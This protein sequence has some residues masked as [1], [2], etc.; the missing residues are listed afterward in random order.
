MKY[1]SMFVLAAAAL[2]PVL[3]A[4]A[5]PKKVLVVTV[6]LGYRH[7]PSIAEA[8]K[9]LPQLAAADGRFAV[10]FVSQPPGAPT[11][12]ATPKPGPAGAEDP[13]F[14]AAKAKFE[15]DRQAFQEAT[16]KWTP[17]VVA[18]L[19]ALSPQNLKKYDAVLFMSTTGDLPL[20]DKQGFLDW[21]AAGHAFIGVHAA[22]DTFHGYPA[23][24]D[25]IG[26]EFKTHG[27]QVAVECLNE[28]P[29][30]A[31]MAHLPANWPVFD[32][33]YQFKNF[34]RAKVHGLLGLDKHPNNK[35]PGDYPL[36]WCRMFGTGRVF[37]TALGHR[38]D[39]WNP[40]ATDNGKR[41]NPA[42][43]AQQFQRHLLGGILWAL[44]LAPGDATP[45]P[46]KQ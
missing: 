27:P 23:F 24:I 20:P 35:T 40:E 32:E 29:A 17:S 22:T 11:P 30:H 8:E 21:I 13:A 33:I 1:L 28:D 6:T 7:G 19:E 45:Q 38:N 43:T 2:A 18:V 46:L 12:P 14:L 36:A 15:T 34:D 37:Y 5:A 44:G 3:P 26:G 16:E 39:I 41:V 25:M 10:D 9:L 31:A 42:G 4:S